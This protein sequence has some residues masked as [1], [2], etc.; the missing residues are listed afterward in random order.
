MLSGSMIRKALPALAVTAIVGFSFLATGGGALGAALTVVS[1]YGYGQ[2]V[3]GGGLLKGGP[4]S[5]GVTPGEDVFI[6]GN[7]DANWM[8]HYNTTT[9]GTWSGYVQLGG[10]TN[11][12][13]TA[14]T[15]T[16]GK[17]AFIRGNDNQMWQDHWN[18]SAWSGWAP[19]GGILGSG[20]SA[21]YQNGTTTINVF[22]RGGDGAL[23]YET[24]TDN[25]VSFTGF[26]GL[27]GVLIGDPGATSWAAGRVDVFIRGQD[28][29]L[30]HRYWS[31]GTWSGWEPLG[32]ILTSGPSV[33]SCA[34]GH[35]DI[36]VQGQGG[37]YYQK[38]WTGTGWTGWAAVAGSWT[39]PP[40]VTCR[41]GGGGLVDVF[42]RGL[43][44][45]LWTV[46]EPA[47]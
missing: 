27:G 7:D 1:T 37:G 33:T 21:D 3:P 14:V 15:T 17:D 43:D 46:A 47:H 29:Q 31:A 40:S 10:L 44:G 45:A 24:S 25:G 19:R 22:V 11:A 30:W 5:T 12:D 39:G 34:A 36:V 41:P 4:G 18:G 13:P 23:Y 9:T 16:I 28:N 35:L 2:T 38:G 42:G 20:P 6:R 26:Q 8:N 32:G